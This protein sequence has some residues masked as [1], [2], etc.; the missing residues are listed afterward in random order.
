MRT[1]L[2]IF[3]TFFPATLLA[4]DGTFT[5]HDAAYWIN[6]L[7]KTESSENLQNRTRWYA[8]YA[9]GELG[10]QGAPSVDALCQRLLDVTE[11]EY[12]RAV[13]AWALGRIQ[14]KS[15]IGALT[16]ALGSKMDAVRI[17]AARALGE[18][19][20][21]A[22]QA[23]ETLRA[24]LEGDASDESR[25]ER[26]IQSEMNPTVKAALAAALW[27]VADKDS[28]NA[29]KG[30][31]DLLTAL[32]KNSTLN[33][34]AAAAELISLSRDDTKDL[35]E[36]YPIL[37]ILLEKSNVDDVVRDC[38]SIL[39]E[40]KQYEA[41]H[42]L[43]SSDNAAVQRRALRAICLYKEDA[44]DS[45]YSIPVENVLP[46][47][48]SENPITRAWAIRALGLAMDNDAAQNAVVGAVDDDD[49]R[50]KKAARKALSR[51]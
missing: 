41:V 2:L 15:A 11:Y 27:K 17:S 26:P 24:V 45:E 12:T 18:F 51:K 28:P 50:V 33:R 6:Q 34:F 4:Q 10:A 38:G 25:N 31:N 42:R 32:K 29:R 37:A 40:R 1:L 48:Q 30:K 22:R 16:E 39:M 43:L 47:A 9:L 13:C 20:E 23:A 19:G 36:F 35:M 14:D 5:G 21:N 8:A 3:L 7:T 46:I 49:P 44:K